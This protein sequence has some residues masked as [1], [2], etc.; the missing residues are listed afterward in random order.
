MTRSAR[1]TASRSTR[2]TRPSAGTQPTRPHY[3]QAR[4]WARFAYRL[5]RGACSAFDTY[6][7]KEAALSASFAL[8]ARSLVFEMTLEDT[9]PAGLARLAGRVAAGERYPE[10]VARVVM[11]D[12]D[13]PEGDEVHIYLEEA[14]RTGTH[15][16]K[17]LLGRLPARDA[18]WVAPLIRLESDAFGT[19]PVLRYHVTGG[20][21]A[22]TGGGG[23]VTVAI[24]R[25][26]EAAAAWLDWADDRAAWADAH[27]VAEESPFAYRIGYRDTVPASTGF[28]CMAY[29][30]NDDEQDFEDSY[31]DE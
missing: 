18:I 23:D 25:A 27:A 20:M 29:E 10:L 31:G 26:H 16:Q 17:H 19:G 9:E 15:A 2:S 14:D 7:T 30:Q 21:A 4:T 5:N 28:G 12:P 22:A 8:R 11:N 6:T 24:S 1:S 3:A 13:D